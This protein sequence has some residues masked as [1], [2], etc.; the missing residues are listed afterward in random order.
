MILVGDTL[1]ALRSRLRDNEIKKEYSDNELLDFI[2]MAYIKIASNLRLFTKNKLY[3]LKEKDLIIPKDF[4]SLISAEAEGVSL[5]I[6]P[7]N[8]YLKNKHKLKEN[9]LT[10]DNHKIITNIEKGTLS[11]NYNY[12]KRVANI[13]DYLDLKDFL[14]EGVIFYCMF[15]ALQKEPRTD[16]L[17]KSEYYLNLFNLEL[18]YAEELNTN[19][20]N[21]KD[22]LS[23]FQRI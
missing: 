1:L 8:Y 7:Y 20:L 2:N 4:I 5:N 13:E 22:L 17:Q 18:K 6:I 15:L 12:I 11:L 14:L 19:M 10:L 3:Q 23:E 9:I 16:S 21:Q